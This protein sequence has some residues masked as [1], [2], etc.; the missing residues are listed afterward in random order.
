[1]IVPWQDLSKDALN[2]II[3]EFIMR[4][5]TDYGAQE[6]SLER[7]KLELLAQLK[8]GYIVLVY[9]QLHENVNLML[10]TEFKD[11]EYS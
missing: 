2:G 8:S 7:K 9:S 3:E 11:N 1:M 4:E 10:A 5:G 6:I